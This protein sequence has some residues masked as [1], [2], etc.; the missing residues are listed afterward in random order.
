ME[1]SAPRDR[2]RPPAPPNRPTPMARHRSTRRVRPPV[3][4]HARRWLPAPCFALLLLVAPGPLAPQA[5]ERT[6]A[7]GAADTIPEPRPLPAD[8]WSDPGVRA[9]LERAQ[10]ARTA[11]T[12]GLDSFQGRI[13]ERL[14]AG[15]DAARF[16][17]ERA[18]FVE[19]RAG[20]I[21]WSADGDRWVRWEGA[22]RDIPI[23]G[24]SSARSE[25]QARQLASQ[26]ASELPWGRGFEPRRDRLVFGEGSW[27]LD[28]LADTAALHYRFHSGDTLRITLPEDGRVVRLVE[29]RVEPRRSEFRLVSGSLW[30]EEEGGALARAIY[31]PA[32]PFDLAID[33]DGDDA[34]D[35]PGFLQ[36]IRAEIRV[37][38]VDHG[39]FDFQWWIPRRFL[40]EGE[41]S[42]G[43]LV[44]FPLSVE[45][46]LTELDVNQ[47]VGTEF[48]EAELP[49]GWTRTSTRL[50]RSGDAAEG[51]S[52]TIIRLV[53]PPGDLAASPSIG[54]LAPARAA[55]F[56]AGELRE[57]EA[58]LGSL[59]PTPG[60]GRVSLHWGLQEG[61]TRFNR[62][63]GL[64]TGL[65]ATVPLPGERVVSGHL[66]VATQAPIPTAEVAY[67]SGSVRRAWRAAAYHRLVGA[68]DW[69]DPL[70]LGASTGNLFNGEGPT[71]WFRAAGASVGIDR[72]GVR[73]RWRA[74]AFV[75]AHRPAA[76]GTR[77]HLRR[78]V[79]PARRLP[80]N[81]EAERGT[82][83]G[84]RA[85]HRWQS[86]V[87]PLRPRLLTRGRLEGARSTEAYGR[88]SVALTGLLPLGSGWDTALEI[89]GGGSVGTLP[90]QRRFF[91][92]GAEGYRPIEVGERE[93]DAF[94]LARAEVGRGFTGARVVLF[95]DALGMHLEDGAT[96][97]LP[98]VPVPSPGWGATGYGAGIGVSFLD[99]L[100]RADLSRELRPHGGWRALFYL[101]ALF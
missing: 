24:L 47:P 84:F 39:L 54:H 41:A 38:S 56:S 14:Y 34:G 20:F 75:E 67:R 98:G 36:P 10:A 48:D 13:W 43:R 71:P 100:L 101:D 58:R 31:R 11:G 93:G 30:F 73:A 17:R 29:V 26:L 89:G 7:A 78:I 85:E 15:L 81:F 95:A 94:F 1:G 55:S 9:L 52:L 70:G 19:E 40:F 72:V 59:L 23:A 37:V 32:R 90:V 53:P 87:D 18:L 50:A 49:E 5:P 57:I 66:R 91:P 21:R 64:A 88:G 82:W 83:A 61:I 97:S 60:L 86:G 44:R 51:D 74:E 4:R 99:G 80:D 35:V 3:R 6:D 62:I 46:T 96:P 69:H 25:E 16:R 65:G 63:E 77:F 42:I 22:R 27:A 33:G 92:G 68:S 76:F 45:W 2:P 79:D 28:P 8:S 12:A